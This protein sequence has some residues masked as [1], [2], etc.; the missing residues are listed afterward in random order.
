MPRD[1]EIEIRL[2]NNQLK[3]RRK[4]LGFSQAKLSEA[5]G[6][7]HSSYVAL[8]G[9]RLSPRRQD[10][11]WRLIAKK[12]INFL[13]VSPEE[14]FPEW[15]DCVDNPVITRTVDAA[16]V[17]ALSGL[18]DYTLAL[19][20]S[21]GDKY[22]VREFSQ[23]L[24]GA[25]ARA[26]RGLK[27]HNPRNAWI[28]SEHYGLN[29]G[30]PR[31]MVDIAKELGISRSAVQAIIKDIVRALRQGGRYLPGINLPGKSF[32]WAVEYAHRTLSELNGAS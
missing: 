10:G 2:R 7:P 14:L 17:S 21:P 18:G 1:L 32:P 3:S 8:E 4:A 23:R 30:M 27:E 5:A 20:E 31:T 26:L 28:L 12:L 15:I 6:V 11:R 22:E 24:K 16:E 25:V 13:A 19:T 29:G 9:L